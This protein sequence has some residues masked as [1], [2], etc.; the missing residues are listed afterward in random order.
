MLGDINQSKST[1]YGDQVGRDK[2]VTYQTVEV[3][4]ELAPAT[5]IIENANVTLDDFVDIDAD[6]NNTVLIKKLKDGGFNSIARNNAKI[7][8]LRIVSTIFSIVK[9]ENGKKILMAKQ[10]C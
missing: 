9:N 1:V 10:L 7:Q 6:D 2:N 5:S 4:K 3:K 8:K